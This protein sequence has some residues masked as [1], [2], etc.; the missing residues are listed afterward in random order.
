MQN[1]KVIKPQS[2]YQIFIM[3]SNN[4]TNDDEVEAS[5]WAIIGCSIFVA[6]ILLIAGTI[7]FRLRIRKRSRFILFN[8][9]F[10]YL[11]L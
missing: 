4:N 10:L 2:K 6:V 5:V 8:G 11:V 1:P 3:Y 9:L 7:F